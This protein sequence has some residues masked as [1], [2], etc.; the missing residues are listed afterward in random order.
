MP[1]FPPE[2]R[3]AEATVF[4]YVRFFV[5]EDGK[6]ETPRVARADNPALA[7]SALKTVQGWSFRPSVDI[8][9][10]KAVRVEMECRFEFKTEEQPSP[11][12][13]EK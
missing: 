6:V 13:F 2:M 3:T 5:S 7:A 10:R 12:F 9:T 1:T 11:P 4:V 8:R